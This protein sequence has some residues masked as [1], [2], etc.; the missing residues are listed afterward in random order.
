MAMVVLFRGW[1]MQLEPVLSYMTT[2][3]LTSYIWSLHTLEIFHNL[4]N[5]RSCKSDALSRKEGITWSG[6]PLTLLRRLP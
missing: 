1:I 6:R 3:R 2:V 5:I 4:C